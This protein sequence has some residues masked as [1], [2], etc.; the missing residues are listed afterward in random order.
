M[1]D[2][3]V[4]PGIDTA[5]PPSG[6]GCVECEAAD[7]PAWWVHLRRCAECGHVGCCD[8]SPNQ[9]AT[10]HFR[11]TGH[12]YMHSYE[13]GED[14]YW[15]FVERTTFEGPELAPPTSHPADQATP[16]PAD[17][18]PANWADLIHR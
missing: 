14:W 18:V 7:P 1:D 12:R 4:R 13:P 16:G 5:V 9:H 8:S 2:D 10:A 17:R 6:P 3:A 15:D 11:G